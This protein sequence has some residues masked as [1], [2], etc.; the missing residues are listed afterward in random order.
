MK[1]I[2]ALTLIVLI[3]STILPGQGTP[4]EPPE[5]LTRK[6]LN[7]VYVE[8]L[9]NG[10]FLTLNYEKLLTDKLGFRVGGLVVPT[11]GKLSFAGTAM[12]VAVWGDSSF[13]MEAGLGVMTLMGE[14]VRMAT[15]DINSS[16]LAL[17]GTIGVRYQPKR[18]GII[19]RFGFTPIASL[20]GDVIPW[21]GAGIG[22][23]FR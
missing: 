18:K 15:D 3:M 13:C 22:Y 21:V 20:G 12:G 14:Y 7:S 9:G 4:P 23:S 2:F 6:G 5:L 19:L 11:E 16:A 10:L 17:T 1:K 8:F